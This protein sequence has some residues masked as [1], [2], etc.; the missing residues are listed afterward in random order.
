M[1]YLYPIIF[2]YASLVLQFVVM[3]FITR[4][5]SQ[6][7][8]GIYLQLFGI[9]NATY[10]FVGFGIPDGI[11]KSVAHADALDRRHEIR[12]LV[13]RAALATGSTS[14]VMLILGVTAAEL[15]NGGYGE[16][17]SLIILA[18]IWWLCYGATFF[19]AQVLVALGESGKGAFF[20]YPAMNIALFGTSVPYLALATTPDIQAT[21]VATIIGGLLCSVAALATAGFYYSTFPSSSE[22]VS[23]RP[24][25]RLG[26]SIG[27]SRVLQ[28]SIHWIPVWGIGA[29]HGAAAAATL[30]TASRLNVAI[31]AVMAAIRFTIRPVIVRHAARN[32]WQEIAIESSKVATLATLVSF[33]ALAGT[34]LLGPFAIGLIFGES[35][36]AS[37]LLLAILLFGTLGECVG[38]PVDEILKMTSRANIVLAILIC[39]TMSEALLVWIFGGFDVIVTAVIQA[40][41]FV[42]MYGFMLWF[43]WRK[44]G[45]WVGANF[46]PAYIQTLF[47]RRGA[48]KGAEDI[49]S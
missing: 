42:G 34:L 37:A 27:L 11:V 48:V 43:V 21:L 40:G 45:V 39:A 46:T 36:R 2:R 24:A 19:A 41:T 25:M 47:P 29:F 3:V 18:A 22:P 30:G 8:A 38:G 10:V 23:L 26:F 16:D 33:V 12:P 4:R 14:L 49:L 44:H 15:F 6:G 32:D 28:S 35:Y 7:D 13:R 20:F 5:L 17:R 31:A 1:R 9:I